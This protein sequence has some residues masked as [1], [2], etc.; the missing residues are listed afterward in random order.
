MDYGSAMQTVGDL[1]KNRHLTEARALLNSILDHYPGDNRA[2]MVLAKI[3]EAFASGAATD[4]PMPQ[5][6]HEEA[7]PRR[8]MQ[9]IKQTIS[10]VAAVPWQAIQDD[11][12][13]V[14]L[15]LDSL[16]LVEITMALEEDRGFYI[17]YDIADEMLSDPD[18]LTVRRIAQVISQM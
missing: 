9:A 14:D 6:F 10:Q 16:D 15:D 3:D 18:T 8:T 17:D 4:R 5:E 11:A 2:Q 7:T 12:P 1:I 13:L